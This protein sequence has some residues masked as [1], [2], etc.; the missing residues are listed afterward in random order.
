MQVLSNIFYFRIFIFISYSW[1]L[2]VHFYFK[3]SAAKWFQPAA[4]HL[5]WPCLEQ[6]CHVW[7]MVIPFDASSQ[8]VASTVF[9]YTCVWVCTGTR[10]STTSQSGHNCQ[11]SNLVNLCALLVA[12]SSWW[13]RTWLF[14][15]LCL[16]LWLLRWFNFPEYFHVIKG[17]IFY[18]SYKKCMMNEKKVLWVFRC[19]KFI[20]IVHIPE[21]Y[22][23]AC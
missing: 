18:G 5:P 17:S 12:S 21:T 8:L 1:I 10:K 6:I 15:F 19:W 11:K 7:Q 4:Y 14:S 23:I 20:L 22:W 13:V 3:C 16:V 9:E 2:L